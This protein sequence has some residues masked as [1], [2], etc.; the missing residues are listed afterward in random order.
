MSSINIAVQTL[1]ADADVA[2]IVGTRVYPI[3]PDPG[4]Q[5][6]YVCVY[7]VSE[8]EEDLIQGASQIRDGRVS[9]E[10]VTAGDVPTLSILG[11]KV[12]N[13]MRD[14]IEFPIAGCIATTRK[15]D[16]DVTNHSRQTN[17]NAVE[18]TVQRITDYYIFWRTA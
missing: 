2:A 14:K 10:S 18:S 9:L 12:I 17:G 1:L 4:A 7:L 13:A 5:M 11:E 15:A 16:S 3:F 8:T 6:P